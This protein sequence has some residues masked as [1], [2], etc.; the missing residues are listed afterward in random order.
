MANSLTNQTINSTYQQ[1]L[2][3]G[4]GVTSTLNSV[5][6]GGGLQ[7][8]L[9]VSTSSVGLGDISVAT[10]TVTTETA[11]ANL[12]LSANG[13]GEVQLLKKFGY[14]AGSG[15]SITQGSTSGKA[16]A[17]T[18]NALAGRIIMNNAAL[19]K[20]EGVDFQL[21]N[22]FIAVSDVIIVNIA[23]GATQGA[24]FVGVDS[25]AAGSCNIHLHNLTVAPSLSEAIELNFVVIKGAST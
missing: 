17:V 7:T 10:D 13:A 25:I 6:S 9:K 14:G 22:S 11:D 3:V 15:G 16:T 4:A 5:Y 20:N 24:Y 18:L 19:A 12:K 8:P 1:V 23:S 21:T 2:H